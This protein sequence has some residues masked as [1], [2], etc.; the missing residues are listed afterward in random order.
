MISDSNAIIRAYLI[1]QSDLTDIVSTRIF[2]PALPENTTLPAVSFSTVGGPPSNPNI[3]K[4]VDPTV[5]FDCWA[6][7]PIEAREV[8]RALRS[9]LQG[10]QMID[11]V[12]SG[13][14]FSIMS[15]IEE[16]QGQDII[17]VELPNYF[18]VLTFFKMMIRVET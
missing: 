7:N 1:T 17:E 8:Y 5:Q 6:D 15:S 18:R 13:T 3:T 16:G 12:V 2:C 11:V 14:T 9:A 10:I 4:I